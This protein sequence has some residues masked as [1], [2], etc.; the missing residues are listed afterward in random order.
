MGFLMT[1]DISLIS[2]ACASP[3]HTR[4]NAS[5][6]KVTYFISYSSYWVRKAQE[7]APAHHWR[8]KTAINTTLR[9]GCS[10]LIMPACAII[11]DCYIRSI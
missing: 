2:R 6:N 9:S 1:C 10:T 7:Q 5:S 8:L 11:K 3:T 4:L